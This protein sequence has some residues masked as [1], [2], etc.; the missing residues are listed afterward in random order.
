M[1]INIS[2]NKEKYI[3]KNDNEKY[4]NKKFN[5]LSLLNRTS[6]FHNFGYLSQ[7]FSPFPIKI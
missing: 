4:L 3:I 5:F 1:I 6:S 7:I 2:K